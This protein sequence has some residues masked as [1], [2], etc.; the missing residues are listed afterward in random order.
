MGHGIAL[1]DNGIIFP[2]GVPVSSISIR[3]CLDSK[4]LATME[5]E[6]EALADDIAYMLEFLDFDS[7]VASF[8][9]AVF[10][11]GRLIIEAVRRTSGTVMCVVVTLFSFYPLVAPFL[12]SLISGMGF[13]FPQTI[14]YLIM[15]SEGITGTPTK[16]FANEVIGF[17]FFGVVLQITGGGDFF[18]D[19]AFA[20]MG[21]YRGGPAKV[22]VVSSGFMG[23]ISGSVISNAPRSRLRSKHAP[24]PAACSC[25]PSWV[26]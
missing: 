6:K 8:A 9:N 24:P 25:R 3:A 16:I 19:L 12:P 11:D 22:S 26:R 15:G 4:V 2:T 13:D 18:M 20:L 14:K 21:K 7:P 23:S 10:E 5:D 1:D 17:L